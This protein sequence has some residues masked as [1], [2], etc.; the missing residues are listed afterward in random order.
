MKLLW[1]E[2][3]FRSIISFCYNEDS[4][5]LEQVVQTICAAY[6]VKGLQY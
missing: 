4:Q 5:V 6:I 2:I 1:T 3:M